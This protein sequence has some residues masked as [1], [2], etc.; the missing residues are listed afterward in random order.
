MTSKLRVD[1]GI[2]VVSTGVPLSAESRNR[3]IARIPARA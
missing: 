1:K 3:T 2:P